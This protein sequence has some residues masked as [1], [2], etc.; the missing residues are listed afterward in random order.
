MLERLLTILILLLHCT[1]LIKRLM[2]LEHI[3]PIHECRIHN[4]RTE[5]PNSD[6]YGSL[7]RL[8][9]STLRKRRVETDSEVEKV[10]GKGARVEEEFYE[11][12]IG[13]FMG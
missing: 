11:Y 8:N 7:E 9:T 4:L 5:T 6:S 3:P 2:S 12:I 10:E 1:P 13:C